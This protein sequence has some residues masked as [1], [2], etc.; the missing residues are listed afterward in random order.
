[1]NLD[2]DIDTTMVRGLDYYND[3]IFEIMTTDESLKGAAT[4]AG[5]GRYSGLV[6]EFGGPETPGVGFGIG[7]ER[8]LDLLQAQNV[9]PT[10]EQNLDFYVVNIGD[11]TDVIATKIVQAVR[12]FGYVAE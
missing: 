6:E 3:T 10:E 4:I 1:L 7:V 11:T 2:F 5:G 12:S 8:L 9:A